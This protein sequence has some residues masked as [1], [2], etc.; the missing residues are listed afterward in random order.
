M[1]EKDPI[2]PTLEELIT[3]VRNNHDSMGGDQRMALA[4]IQ[5]HSILAT[6]KATVAYE[7][8][9]KEIKRATISLVWVTGSL[10]LATFILA[11]ITAFV[12]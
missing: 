1:L 8:A 7:T 12:E 6:N 3:T 4:Q 9:G 10:A 11:Y 5:A 2:L